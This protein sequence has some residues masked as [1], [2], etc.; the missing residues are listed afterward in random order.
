[1]PAS[2]HH[3]DGCQ[4]DRR[5]VQSVGR[6]ANGSPDAPDL[7]FIC[8]VEHGRGRAFDPKRQAYVSYQQLEAEA[9]EADHQ[10]SNH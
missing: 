1:M 10:R 2:T 5:D 4:R 6:D 3:C 9:E 7:C 8:R